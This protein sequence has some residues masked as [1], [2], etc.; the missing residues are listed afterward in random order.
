MSSS[1]TI[2]SEPPSEW[3]Y[4]D[5]DIAH[6]F[7]FFNVLKDGRVH[8]LL[9]SPPEVPPSYGSTYG[10]SVKDVEIT[11]DVSVRVF[12]PSSASST[13][14][15]LPV[16]LYI[17]GGGFC[18]LSAFAEEYTRL[19]SIIASQSNVI[20]V[21]VDYGIFPARPLPACYDDSWAALQW[22]AS[23]SEPWI[24]TT[25]IVAGSSS[26]GILQEGTSLTP[27]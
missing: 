13:T 27:Y 25:P 10:V 4:T 23:T 7:L 24:N 21:S 20:I 14:E 18:M 9:P 8:I 11:T 12:L 2:T 22:L 6:K 5:S 19:C 16:L 17:H 15:K 26:A 1:T 3:N